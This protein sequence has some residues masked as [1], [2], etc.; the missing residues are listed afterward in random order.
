MQASTG[1]HQAAK[2]KQY[3]RS[4]SDLCHYDINI[5]FSM[6][7]QLMG[8][9][10]E[11]GASLSAFLNLPDPRKWNRQFNVLENFTH[12]AIQKVKN[13]SEKEAAQEEVTKTL[14]EDDNPIEQNL[15]EID[16]PLHHVRASYDMGWQ[17]RSPGGKYGSLT[18]HGLL[19]RA[20]SKK[21]LDSVVYNKKC[22]TCMK[23][24]SR[25]GTY[26]DVKKHICVRNYV[27]TSKA[28]EA[29]AL[30]TML[31]RSVQKNNISICTIISDD[32][33]N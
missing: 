29:Q 10:G 30:V 8:V 4:K 11:H 15:L 20:I 7:L 6:A 12:N 2:I 14:Q 19:V 21:V 9:G 5:L 25:G 13:L 28:V 24:L 22:G 26:N 1:N 33:S 17:V 27:G 16:L 18:G 32:N 3:K 23:H 31:E